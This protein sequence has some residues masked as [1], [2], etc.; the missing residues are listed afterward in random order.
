MVQGF[1]RDCLARVESDAAARCS[2]CG[3]TRLIRHPELFALTLAHI[4]CD[5]FYASVEKRDDPALRDK[6][7]IVGGGRARRRDDGLLYRAAF[8]RALG[9]A[10]VPGAASAVRRRW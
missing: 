7:L 5:A 3:S 9:D 4:D 2:A 6:P 10:D 1:C 8:G